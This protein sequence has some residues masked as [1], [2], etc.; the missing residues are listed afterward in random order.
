VSF[1]SGIDGTML[2]LWQ[3]DGANPCGRCKS[4][5]VPCKYE[6]PIRQSKENMRAEI[7][8]L[9][10][11]Q[12]QSDRVLAAIVSDDGSENILQRLRDGETL[13]N[14]S[15]NLDTGKE[16]SFMTSNL[17]VGDDTTNVTAY[18]Q[19]GDQQ[20]IQNAIYAAAS[21]TNSPFSV[22]AF[23]DTYGGSMEGQNPQSNMQWPTWGAAGSTRQLSNATNSDDMVGWSPNSHGL[24]QS[25]YPLIGTWHE[26]TSGSD[27]LDTTVQWAREQGRGYILG[28]DFGSEEDRNSPRVNEPWTQVTSDGEFVEHLMALYF[29]WEYPTFAS[30]SKEHFLDDFRTGRRRHCSSLLVNAMLAVGCRFSTQASARADADNSNT[31]G[32][33]FFAEAVRLLEQEKDRHNLTTIQALGLMSIREAS[34]GR[35]SESIYYAGQSVMIA[36]EMGL[37]LQ[38]QSG[39]GDDA[40][41]DHAVKSATFWGAFSLDQ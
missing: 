40:T 29:C 41:L 15:E 26:Q 10:K 17:N 4:Q 22:E 20:A 7:D 23:G 16:K 12:H 13:E 32:D 5:A 8:Q 25:A 30:L 6:I 38:S 19:P 11:Q 21:L 39:G 1:R 28:N 36:I 34:S 35:S 33:H 24:S 9:R 18:R 27:S 3:C 14:I 2:M 37:H 31:A